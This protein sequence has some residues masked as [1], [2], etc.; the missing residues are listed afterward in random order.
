MGK[1]KYSIIYA[2]TRPQISERISVGIVLFGEG[3]VDIRYS[4]Y[5]LNVLKQLYKHG[6]YQF[7]EKAIKDINVSEKIRHQN[8]IAYLSRYSNN[9]INFSS[10]EDI[11]LEDTPS[12]KNWLF[13]HY[14][15]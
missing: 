4:Q 2:V 5:K 10:L 12:N 6:E 13:N 8:D 1:L 7:V 9:L 14:V 3:D 15:D 11:D